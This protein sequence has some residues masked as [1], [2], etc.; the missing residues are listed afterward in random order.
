MYITFFYSL[1]VCWPPRGTSSSKF[2]EDQVITSFTWSFFWDISLSSLKCISIHEKFEKQNY[3]TLHSLLKTM[4][5]GSI[6]VKLQIHIRLMLKTPVSTQS[7]N[8]MQLPEHYPQGI[9][10]F[11]R[12]LKKKPSIGS[13]YHPPLFKFICLDP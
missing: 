6:P 2:A 1:N 9:R 8:K 4:K 11:N 12:S 13:P 10:L 7:K 5:K 3:S